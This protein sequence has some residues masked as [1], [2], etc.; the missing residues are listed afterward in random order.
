MQ[1]YGSLEFIVEF[2]NDFCISFNFTIKKLQW[3]LALN[4]M[5]IIQ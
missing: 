2:A 5:N 1:L 4:K 3:I